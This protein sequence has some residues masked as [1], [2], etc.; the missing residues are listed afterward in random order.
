MA[1]SKK[2]PPRDETRAAAEY[3]KLNKK[4]VEDLVTADASN[5]PEV[6]EAEIRKYQSGPKIKMSGWL[7]IVLL[8]AWFAAVVCYFFAWE[9]FAYLPDV[10]DQVFVTGLAM[11]AV[12]DLLLNNLLK[13]MEKTPRANDP[14]MMVTARG[15]VSFPLNV[16]YGLVLVYCVFQTYEVGGLLLRAVGIAMP[17]V[18]PI[19]FGL[20]T[21]GWDMLF[22]LMKRTL[23][24][25]VEDAKRTAGAGR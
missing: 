8:K 12:M 9:L 23:K 4:A 17:G 20:F 24:K 3:Y 14:W 1:K 6:S 11:G 21:L 13:F 25:I 2:A 16:L 5:S 18:E 15:F 19:L 22:L 10:L 7:K